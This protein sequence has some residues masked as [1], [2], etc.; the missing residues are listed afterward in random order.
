MIC[1]GDEIGREQRGNN[2]AYA[3]DNELT[4][5]DWRLDATKCGLMQFTRYLIELR[6]E[7]PNFHRRKFF[8][9]RRINPAGVPGTAYRG[10]TVHD[11]RWLRPDGEDMTEDEW[12]AGWVRCLGLQLTGSTLD[13]VNDV[14]EPLYD[15]TFLLMMNPH[16]EP[17]DFY[18]P[19]TIAKKWKLLVDTKIAGAPEPVAVEAGRPFT[20]IPRS[21]AVFSAVEEPP[22]AE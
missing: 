11:I 6:R 18:L 20:L 10:Q 7:H 22:P 1:G 9:D 12:H 15:D 19:N 4:W 14:G 8:Q 17:I 5:Y 3:Q 21:M 16:F 13:D 2:N